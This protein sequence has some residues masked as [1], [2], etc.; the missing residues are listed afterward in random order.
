MPK[1]IFR[2]IWV[3]SLFFVAMVSRHSAAQIFNLPVNNGDR[4]N[5]AVNLDAIQTGEME[6]NIFLVNGQNPDGTPLQMPAGSVS[7]L[8]LKAPGKAQHEYD[9]GYQLLMRKDLQGAVDHL[10]HAIN[11]YSSYVAAHNALGTAYLNLGQKQQARDQFAQA[12]ALDD[13]LPNSYLNLGCAQL[14]LEEYP[15]AQD[16]LQKASSIAPLDLQLQVALTYAQLKNHDYPAVVTTADQVHNR[17]HKNATIVHFFAA[18]AQAAQNNLAGAQNEM[19]TLLQEDPKSP[20]ADQFRTILEQIK[21]ERNRPALEAKLELIQ[22]VTVSTSSDA[23]PEEQSRYAQHVLQDLKERR[24][25]A[26][27]E[28]EPEP[29]C[30]NCTATMASNSNAP[31]PGSGTNFTGTVIRTKVEEVGVFFSATDHGKSVTNLT[32]SDIVVR[33]DNRP[34][35]AVLSFR[36]ESELPLRLGLIIDTSESVHERISFERAAAVKFLQ[37]VVTGKDDLA[38]VIGVNNSVLLVQDFTGDQTLTAR[39]VNQLAPGGGTALW[40]AVDFAANKLATRVESQPVARVLVVLSDGEDNSSTAT[41]KQAI[42]NSLRGETAVYTISTRD[43]G[44]QWPDNS[45]G[46]HALKTLSELTGGTIFIPGSVGGLGGSFSD[47]QRVIRS[48]YLLSYKPADFKRDGRYRPIEIKAQKE[49]RQLKVY[50]RKGY[51]AAVAQPHSAEP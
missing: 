23:T 28:A 45:T 44:D 42:A 18:E 15:G 17:K 50:S 19:E 10:S 35:A 40:D 51:Y 9:K 48:R 14:S 30:P 26:E 3:L 2:L 33:D 11:I 16:S 21:R 7:A 37:M 39:A 46:E 25:I 27:A 5:S 24:Q 31:L 38:F 4:F 34:P 36:N 22:P 12:V 49:G 1:P 29:T 32:P 43:L 6:L 20:S 8:D 47:L 13:H 41:L